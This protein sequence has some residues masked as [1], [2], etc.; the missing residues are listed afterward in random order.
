[1]SNGKGGVRG[2]GRELYRIVKEEKCSH[3]GCSMDLL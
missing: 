3:Y 1:M 2:L